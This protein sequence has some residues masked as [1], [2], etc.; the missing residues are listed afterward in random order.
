MLDCQRTLL[1]VADVRG[2]LDQ[3]SCAG[4][5][6]RVHGQYDSGPNHLGLGYLVC[7][8][9]QQ[10]AHCYTILCHCSPSSEAALTLKHQCAVLQ[11]RKLRRRPTGTHNATADTAAAAAGPMPPAARCVV[12]RVL[13]RVR[14]GG[15]GCAGRQI[16][17]AAA[18]VVVQLLMMVAV[19]ER[20]HRRMAVGAATVWHQ[21]TRAGAHGRAAVDHHMIAAA[22]AARARTV[23]PMAAAAAT[24]L[25]NAR[26]LAVCVTIQF[27]AGLKAVVL[28]LGGGLAQ[29][30]IHLF[31]VHW[32]AA[33]TVTAA[34]T[35]VV[36]D[37]R[38]SGALTCGEFERQIWIRQPSDTQ[39]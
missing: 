6:R 2:Q 25:A 3:Q 8:T 29:I 15:G 37:G 36:L 20:Q 11:D 24:H 7:G 9:S 13:R 12:H 27:L 5:R 22:A 34:A 30:A 33:D 32:A 19:V 4:L 38:L 35:V 31:G 1:A 28:D 14:F 10:N 23:S 39:P 16:A 18:I 26:V 17:V 21:R